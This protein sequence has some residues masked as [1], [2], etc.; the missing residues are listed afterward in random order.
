[1]LSIEFIEPLSEQFSLAQGESGNL[2]HHTIESLGI[3][4]YLHT[5]FE[6]Y[7]SS[8]AKIPHL[9]VT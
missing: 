1:M 2:F 4:G 3:H 8:E 6:V 9:A 7:Y 5:E